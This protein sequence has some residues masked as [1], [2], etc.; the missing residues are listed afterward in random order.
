MTTHQFNRIASPLFVISLLGIWQFFSVLLMALGVWPVWVVWL[1]LVLSAAYLAYYPVYYGLIF[2]IVNFAFFVSLPLHFA[3]SLSMWRVLFVW[4]FVVWLVRQGLASPRRA[5][6]EIKKSFL[7]WDKYFALFFVAALTSLL[8]ARFP[9]QGLKQI[10]LWVTIYLIYFLILQTVKTRQQVMGI[11][12][13]TAVSLVTIITLGYAQLFSSFFTSIGVFWV[14]WASYLSKLYYGQSLSHTFLFSNSWFSATGKALEFRM[15]SIMP[16]SHS[17]ALVAIYCISFLLPLTYLFSGKRQQVSNEP[18]EALELKDEINFLDNNNKIFGY[19]FTYILWSAIRFA[20]LAIVL[21]GTR[22]VWVGLLLPFCLVLLGWYTGFHREA[23]KKI[24]WPLIIIIF[25]FVLSPFINAGLR[26]IQVS[27]FEENFISRAKSIY[28]LRENSTIA[29]LHMWHAS[30]LYAS[31]HPLGT[32]PDNFIVSLAPEATHSNNYKQMAE[33]RSPTFNLPQNQ[34]SAHNLYLN[35]WIEIG[36]VG[37][38]AFGLFWWKFFSV[39]E[40]FMKKYRGENNFFLFFVLEISLTFLWVLAS[41]MF[42]TS[43]LNSRVLVY[44]FISLALSGIIVRDYEKLV[45]SE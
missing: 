28:N 34:V 8:Y 14:Y 35:I 42:D 13:S 19:K 1:N 5:L 11:I 16:D 23:M 30:L 39:V 43:F 10:L 12:S 29:G 18:H 15:F 21:S 7:W 24:F 38:V 9:Y 2:L 27:K 26:V 40:R 25:F 36:L 22:G 33:L 32:G 45:S 6:L 37:L 17:F 3:D 44:F 31:R 20:G 4:L 41:G